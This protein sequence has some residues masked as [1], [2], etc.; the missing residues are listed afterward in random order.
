VLAWTWEGN[1]TRHL[2]VINFSQEPIWTRVR[3]PWPTAGEQW[4][5]TDLLEGRVFDRDG[6]ELAAGGLV[7]GL[8]AW[9]F[10]VLETRR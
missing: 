9:G 5:L 7:V 4:R 6:D 2:V 1:A 3:L 8:P 10:H